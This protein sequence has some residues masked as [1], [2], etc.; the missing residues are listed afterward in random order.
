[1]KRVSKIGEQWIGVQRDQGMTDSRRHLRPRS[2]ITTPAISRKK[3]VN[4]IVLPESDIGNGL[5][6]GA[7]LEDDGRLGFQTEAH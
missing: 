3:D 1:L 4:E 2:R 7:V 5:I 6:C